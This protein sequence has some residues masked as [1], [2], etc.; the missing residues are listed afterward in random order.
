MKT[1][2]SARAKLYENLRL[3]YKW[4]AELQ[5]RLYWKQGV[6]SLK[7][8]YQSNWTSCHRSMPI[9]ATQLICEPA[10]SFSEKDCSAICHLEAEGNECTIAVLMCTMRNQAGKA[11][12][13]R[14][15][16]EWLPSLCH[17]PVARETRGGPW[18]EHEGPV[19]HQR[20]GATPEEG[21]PS[22]RTKKEPRHSGPLKGA[23]FYLGL[24]PIKC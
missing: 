22:T 13:L 20:K 10:K 7:Q 6:Q 8:Q 3:W 19:C 9:N 14:W 23:K 1:K 2:S 17:Q 11:A 4:W 15:I 18:A 12:M 5:G 21:G 16:E 24:P